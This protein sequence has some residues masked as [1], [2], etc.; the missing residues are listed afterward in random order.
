MLYLWALMVCD[1]NCRIYCLICCTSKTLKLP[2]IYRDYEHLLHF[3]TL[4]HLASS[5]KTFFNS[6]VTSL[7]TH[8]KFFLAHLAKSNVSF[9]H[10]LA[11]VVCHYRPH[12]SSLNHLAN[13]NLARMFI[14]WSLTKSMFFCW[15]EVHKWN[16]RPKCV[17]KGVFNRSQ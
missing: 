2:V 3:Y 11:S 10:H 15:S 17:K 7:I 9:S 16:K 1:L 6:R 12:L 8:C 4:L 13:W 14:G 5:G